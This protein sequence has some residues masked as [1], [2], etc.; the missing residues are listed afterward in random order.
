VVHLLEQGK[1]SR[2]PELVPDGRSLSVFSDRLTAPVGKLK[3][4]HFAIWTKLIRFV[5]S[6]TG[7]S[8]RGAAM[9]F[10]CSTTLYGAF[11]THVPFSHHG[12][13]KV[14]AAD[15]RSAVHSL[16]NLKVVVRQRTPWHHRMVCQS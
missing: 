7:H 12:L 5:M 16:P 15:F 10:Y 11:R 14:G 9:A 2:Q 8:Y 1:F 13:P 6:F 3:L 4:P